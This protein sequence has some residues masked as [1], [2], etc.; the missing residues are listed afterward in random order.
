MHPRSHRGLELGLDQEHWV[1]S[2]RAFP[3]EPAVWGGCVH[4]WG[5]RTGETWCH[6]GFIVN[7]VI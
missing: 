5:L 4:L 2:L 3:R 1:R 7:A 6:P